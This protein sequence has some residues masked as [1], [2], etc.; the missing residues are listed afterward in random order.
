MSLLSVLWNSGIH[1]NPTPRYS[2]E[3]HSDAEVQFTSVPYQKHAPLHCTS[4]AGQ[5]E[6]PLGHSVIVQ[7]VGNCQP[8]WHRKHPLSAHP[9]YQF[10]LLKS[11]LSQRL[12]VLLVLELSLTF[13]REGKD[14]VRA[15]VLDMYFISLGETS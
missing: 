7:Y 1:Q 2:G 15:E 8:S 5:H 11:L 4:A 14:T 6:G 3:L 12:L 10:I 9:P 13:V